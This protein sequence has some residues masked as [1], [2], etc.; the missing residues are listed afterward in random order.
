M[1]RVLPSAAGPL[2]VALLLAAACDEPEVLSCPDDLPAACEVA[3][4]WSAEVAPT[5]A[6]TCGPCHGPGGVE[7]AKPLVAHADVSAR[8][9][10]VLS[11][12][13]HCQ[14][15][16][17]DAGAALTDGERALVLQWLVCGAPDN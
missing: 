8:R 17:P 13:Y 3:P 11:Q 14:M 16:G 15:P 4:S 2:T 7:A 1:S 9:T 5:F 12:V 10:S 6:R